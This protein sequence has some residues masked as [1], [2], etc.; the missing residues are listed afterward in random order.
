MHSEISQDHNHGPL[1]T[2]TDP[3]AY[4]LVID[5]ES[6]TYR[7]N[8][9]LLPELREFLSMN[10]PGLQ[11]TTY[12]CQ[13][14]SKVLEKLKEEQ[15]ERK[16]RSGRQMTYLQRSSSFSSISSSDEEDLDEYFGQSSGGTA[17][18]LATGLECLRRMAKPKAQLM[19]WAERGQERKTGAAAAGH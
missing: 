4:E 16:S 2:S 1:H 19:N 12:D 3:A 11:V 10:L 9:K 17:S 5:N 14:D 6:G 18:A 15:R 8:P 7:P 13:G